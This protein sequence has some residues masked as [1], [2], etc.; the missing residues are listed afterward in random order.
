MVAALTMFDVQDGVVHCRTVSR[1]KTTEADTMSSRMNG[2][3]IGGGIGGLAAAIALR[4]VGVQAR[5]FERAASVEEVGAGLS[6]WPNGLRALDAMGLGNAVRAR[7]VRDM[8]SALRTWTGR[9]LVAA[10]A[11]ELQALLGDVSLVIHRGELLGLLRRQLPA[12]ALVCGAALVDV[13][14]NERGIN[15]TFADGSTAQADFL[16][17]ADGINSVVRARL[18][19]E[20][21]PDYA[22]YTAW[23]GVAR[24]D[25]A[26]LLPGV[27]LG[28]GS[29]FGQVPLADGRV[30]WFAT[31]NSPP[32]RARPEGGWKKALTE[33][34]GGWHA[35]IPQLLAATDELAI[36]HND[37]VDRPVRTSWGAG[38][39]MLLGDAAH[40]MTPN[41]GQGANQA[42]EDAQAMARAVA[43]ETSET[44]SESAIAR[45]RGQYERE[46]LAA[47]N[48]VVVQSRRVGRV[49]QLTNPAACWLRDR[50]L[51]TRFAHRAQ[52]SQ[53]Q[54]LVAAA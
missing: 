3:I 1:V 36:L 16:I 35:P 50:L 7:G 37:I 24:F 22:G 32:R 10:N 11:T 18:F 28:R 13:S 44:A 4:R 27:S 46:R 15:A 2:L 26:R 5:V 14:E 53:L 43:G 23:R 12:D 25:H 20:A 38:R 9:V 8:E 52:M 39:V 17:G 41:L 33:L 6:L 34:F 45:I 31:Q 29:Q 19:G 48:A 40:P 30:Y 54:R 21:P 42:L 51:R 47:A 49:M